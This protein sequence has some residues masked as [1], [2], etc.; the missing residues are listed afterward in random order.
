M[1]IKMKKRF[2]SKSLI[3]KIALVLVIILVFEFSVSEPVQAASLGGQLLNPIVNL[4][5]YLADGVMQILQSALTSIDNSFEYIGL[6]G[7]IHWTKV[8]AVIAV[9]AGTLLAAAAIILSGGTATPFVIAVVAAGGLA[10]VGG[11]MYLA[12]YPNFGEKLDAVMFGSSF[13]YSTIYI[14]PETILKNQIKLFDVN[15]FQTFEETEESTDKTVSLSNT[16]R[17]VVSQVYTTIR[18]VALVAMLIVIIYVAIRMLIALTPK[19]KSR[20]KESAINCVIGLVL[21][22][23][24]HFIMSG[25]VTLLEMITN[26]VIF[27]DQTYDID[28]SEI[29]NFLESNPDAYNKAISGVSLEIVGDELYDA[30]EEN[31]DSYPGMQLGTD[32]ESGEN[33]VYVKAS[34]FTEQARYMAQKVYELDADDNTVETWEHIGWAFVYIMLVILTLAFIVM[35]AKRALYMAALTM[36]APIVGVMYPINRA[37]GG[38]SHALN[39]WFKEYIGNLIIQPFHLLLYTIFIGSAM[40]FAIHNPIYVIIAIMGMMAKDY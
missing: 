20:Y 37:N 14:T 23:L 35:Y 19:E 8:F 7:G 22:I 31:I 30:V 13:V 4:V 33:A 6:S 18:D 3:A 39:L 11:V 36:F 12:T 2:L 10:H 25:S 40:A 29:L 38:R 21:I 26:S 34:N 15:Y 9:I 28:E 24:M 1:I 16:L 27:T 17:N 5:V 32:E